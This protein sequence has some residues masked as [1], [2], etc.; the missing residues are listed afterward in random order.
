MWMANP[1]VSF[2]DWWPVVGPIQG[3]WRKSMI[4]NTKMQQFIIN[5]FGE[6][7]LKRGLVVMAVDINS[8]EEVIFDETTP[9]EDLTWGIIASAS[10]PL[11][12]PPVSEINEHQMLVDGGAFSNVE[13]DESILKCREKGY[14]DEHIIVDL[15]LCFDKVVEVKEWTLR[16]AKYESA[17]GIFQRRN[18]FSDFYYYYEEVIRVVRGFPNV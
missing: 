14:D 10:I 7:E 1:V 15:I 12:F 8:G 18:E 2:W 17:W 3:L 9:K 5:V 6:R 16:D 4:D 13:I 11:V